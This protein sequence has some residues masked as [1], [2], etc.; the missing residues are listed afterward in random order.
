MTDKVRVTLAD[1]HPIVLSGLRGLIQGEPD[2]ELVGEASDGLLALEMI[3]EQKP[4]IAVV[5]ISMPELNGLSVAK[6][7]LQVAPSVQMIALTQHED[8]AYVKQAFDAGF[9]GYVL[10]RSAADNLVHAIRA[11]FDAGLYV[12]P[13]VAHRMFDDIPRRVGQSE[14]SIA[15]DLTDREAEVLK[16][17]A[18]GH[19]S[20][21]IA[22]QLDLGVKTIETY[23]ARASEKLG[24]N[25]RA[26]IVRYAT[27]Q[28]W[29][30]D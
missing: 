8:R 16:L 5:D 19:T 24:L 11:V 20:K 10:K 6:R 2:F 29:L 23:K 17:V 22:R 4:D 9:R 14:N 26:E 15:G 25:S 1:D 18:R 30:T 28:G 21:E 27:D 13:A 3:K 12:D 7:I